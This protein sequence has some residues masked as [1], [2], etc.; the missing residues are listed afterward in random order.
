MKQYRLNRLFNPRSGNCLDVAI[1][2]GVFN[3]L[4]FLQGIENIEKTM[5]TLVACGPDA[6][7]LNVGQAPVL[8][9]KPGKDKPALVMRVDVANTYAKELPRFLFSRM[10]GSPVDQALQLDAACVV[11]N[12]FN[13]HNQPEVMDHCIQNILALK[14][15]CDRYGMPMM[16]EPL[17]FKD[18]SQAGGY[19]VDGDLEKILPLV[20]QATE[21]GADIIKADPTDN[22]TDYR[23]VV[24]VARVP[25]LVRGGGKSDDL[26]VLERTAEIMREGVRGLVY[27]RNIIQ[28][29][30]PA[31]MTRA[32]MEVVHAGADARQAARHLST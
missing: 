6:I 16:I 25:V 18:N 1:D 10:I 11:L 23:H 13:I 12:L 4:G 26:G 9:A 7:Q 28:H 3:V 15:A 21:L 20:R 5:D 8:Q 30:N 14:P 31:G 27:G 29:P 32:L 22:V 24:E 19:M 17:V 2:H